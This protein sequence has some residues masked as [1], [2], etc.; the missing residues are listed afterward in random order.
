M[1]KNDHLIIK[2]GAYV[3]NRCKFEGYNLIHTGTH[4]YDSYLGK[5]SYIAGNSYFYK[6]CIGRFC[7]IGQNVRNN[8][9]VHPS[10]KYVSTHPAFLSTKKQAGF[11]FVKETKFE[12]SKFLN[13]ENKIIIENDVWIGNDVKIMD[14]VKIGN[15]AIIGLGSVV[16]KDIEPYSIVVGVPAK[17]LKKRF[18]EDEIKFLLEFKWWEKDFKWLMQHKQYF[19]NVTEFCNNI[20]KEQ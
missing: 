14:G 5:G 11:T 13:K 8:F 17:V 9:A 6:A 15:G 18:S 2:P 10:S 19:N 7:S 20:K 1:R 3:N 16:T 12:E 4:F